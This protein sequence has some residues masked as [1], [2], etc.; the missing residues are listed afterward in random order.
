VITRVIVKE[1]KKFAPGHRVDHLVDMRETE[2]LFRTL[3]VKISVINTYSP[4]I[5]LFSYKY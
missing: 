5:V 2:R 1:G 4:F 3:F